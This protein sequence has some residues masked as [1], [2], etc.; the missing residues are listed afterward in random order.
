MLERVAESEDHMRKPESR[1]EKRSNEWEVPSGRAPA[2]REGPLSFRAA[3]GRILRAADGRRRRG[4][5]T[6]ASA[7]T[8]AHSR[9][10]VVKVRVVQ[11]GSE[12][13]KK[14][15][16]LHLR[17]LE[18]EGVQRDGSA[19]TLYDENGPV[20]R[21][22]FEQELAG[23]KHQF[24]IV[25]SPEDGHALDLEEYVRSYMER[26]EADLRQKLRWAAV[27]HYNTDQP[28]AHLIIRGVDANGAEVRMDREYV[29]HGL[30]RR[31]AELATERLGPRPERSRVDQLKQ[32]AELERYTSLDRVLQRRAEGGIFR[33]ASRSTPDPHMEAALRTRLE[34]LVRLGL[35]SRARNEW[36]LSPRLRPELEQ[37]GRRA[38]GIRAIR[39][40]LPV[41]TNPCRVIDRAEPND[42]HRA[43]LEAGVQGVL[44][45]KGLDEQ[46]QFCAVIETTAGT[47]YYLPISGRV[48]QQARVGQVVELKRA[49][50][51]DAKIEEVARQA[52]WSYD[53]GAVSELARSAYR[54]RLEQLERMGLAERDP[55]SADRW[56]LRPDF[57]AELAQHEQQP[58]WQM[59]SIRMEAQP[60]DGQKTYQGY[61]WLDRVHLDQLGSTGFGGEAQDALRIRYEYLRGIGIT[62][63]SQ[64]LKWKLLDA[65]RR[66][67]E[68]TLTAQGG[69]AVRFPEGLEGTVRIHRESN[70]ERFVEVRSRDGKFAVFPAP[71]DV[72]AFEGRSARLQVGDKGRVRI[73]AID[74]ERGR[75]R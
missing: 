27:N 10:V 56:R 41:S 9:R 55:A 23:E 65:Q 34:V 19:G 3:F 18:R 59:L 24:R 4:A 33:P 73:E 16:K 44:R 31:A 32:E 50:D 22:V 37:M 70:N 52:G 62:P 54:T 57:R 39:A 51:K 11:V 25:L 20:E 53:L 43:E 6:S 13:A 15:A 28:H 68:E 58:Y 66:R 30:R 63:Q 36:R 21:S 45:W 14:A 49:V 8:D 35:A 48:A 64:N 42:A 1:R 5:A 40:V 2:R 74:R 46:G 61:V 72:D 67:L 38:E 75:D 7:A 12:W 17:Y 47:A 71:R 26:L 29:S 69:V 60:L